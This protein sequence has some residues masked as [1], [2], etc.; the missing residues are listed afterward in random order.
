MSKT[1]SYRRKE[2]VHGSPGAGEMK[3][4][5]PALF[6]INEI[7]AEFQ[8]ITTHPLETTFMARLD[9]LQPQ[10]TSAFQKKGGVTGQKLA[11]HL[12]ILQEAK[13][14][15]HSKRAAVLR[16]LCLYL[17]EDDGHLIHEYMD[18][19]G[20]AIPTDMQ[21]WAMGN[22]AIG[23][24]NGDPG[25]HDDIGISVD[26]AIILDNIG[27][28]GQAC[29]VMLGVIYALNLAYP[30]ELRHYYEFIQ[31]VL[32]GMDGEKLSPKVLGLKNKIGVGL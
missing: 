31:K 22:Y 19:E 7:N 20:N 3:M 29:T 4:R 21:K 30:N 8:R 18:I 1:F 23:K 6:H 32:M 5:W 27:S 24:E 17:G 16:A 25:H 28:A 14:D 26:G 2:V 15:V 12:Q 11:K 10:L 13:G 9:S